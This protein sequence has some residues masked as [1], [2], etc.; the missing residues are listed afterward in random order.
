MSE[1]ERNCREER[2]KPQR[3]NRVFA[4]KDLISVMPCRGSSIAS[5]KLIINAD[6]FQVHAQEPLF[7]ITSAGYANL[8]TDLL[9]ELHNRSQLKST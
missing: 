3:R 7:S 8:K 1:S 2:R 6:C 9:H 5:L 4:L